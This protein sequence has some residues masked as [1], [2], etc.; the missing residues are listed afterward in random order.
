MY[1]TNVSDVQ[2]LTEVVSDTVGMSGITLGTHTIQITSTSG[3]LSINGG[4]WGTSG[5]V[6]I[7][8]LVR[9]KVTSPTGSSGESVSVTVSVQGYGLMTWTVTNVNNVLT[10]TVQ[11]VDAVVRYLI[12]AGS[13]CSDT[14]S[15]VDTLEPFSY[16][17]AYDYATATDTAM[18]TVRVKLVVADALLARD[19]GFPYTYQLATDSATATESTLTYGRAL[20]V[21]TA[22]GTDTPLGVLRAVALVTES[23]VASDRADGNSSGELSASASASDEALPRTLAAL[24]V[25]DTAT[26][27]ALAL[28]DV[29]AIELV[30][31]SGVVTDNAES[32]LRTLMLIA[33]KPA[34]A[35]DEAIYSDAGNAAWVTTVDHMALTRWVALPFTEVHQLPDGRIL[36]LAPDG[37]Y[38]VDAAA[39]VDV[40]V[41]TGATDFGLVNVKSLRSGYVSALSDT[42][43]ELDTVRGTSAGA[44]VTTYRPSV[45]GMTVTSQYRVTFGRGR[46][47]R[48]W[49]FA[50]RN[51]DG[52]KITIQDLRVVPLIGDRRV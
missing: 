6:G 7:G 16:T 37:V 12:R 25:S 52:A 11:S 23:A 30:S 32:V 21:D 46:E 8:D 26:G 31:D 43:I 3:Q 33:G 24:L 20:V 39:S 27:D 49:A 1:F 48:Y 51:T 44:A 45:Y 40:E 50:V 34:V 15:A 47:A 9:L 14:A 4:A 22:T 10:D 18:P 17:P 38:E 5:V 28:V 35:S 29:R 41:R 19:S 42:P 2:P 36:G 13:V